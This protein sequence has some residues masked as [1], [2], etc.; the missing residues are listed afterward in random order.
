MGKK[1]RLDLEDLKVESFATTH[2]LESRRGTVFA[3]GDTADLACTVSPAT[4]C[5]ASCD[6]FCNTDQAGCGASM[7]LPECGPTN[8]CG[9]TC[10]TNNTCCYLTDGCQTANATDCPGE[11]NCGWSVDVSC[12]NSCT[13]S[14]C[15]ACNAAC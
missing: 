14:G 6:A 15:T 12:A 10:H 5:G 9:N 3:Q 13:D 11:T 1:L 4:G 7:G 8:T 2:G